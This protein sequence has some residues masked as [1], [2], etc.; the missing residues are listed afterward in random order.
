[1][2]IIYNQAK[3]VQKH[4][5]VQ[6][7]SHVFNTNPLKSA[8]K[9]IITSKEALAKIPQLT[10]EDVHSFTNDN[11]TADQIKK[12]LMANFFYYTQEI[13]VF[14]IT[15]IGKAKL[16]KASIKE[17]LETKNFKKPLEE[18]ENIV[19][20]DVHPDVG[21]IHL[22][23]KA[24]FPGHPMDQFMAPA[25]P[26]KFFPYYIPCMIEF[27]PPYYV[28]IRICKLA[29]RNGPRTHFN[30]ENQFLIDTEMSVSK[31]LTRIKNALTAKPINTTLDTTDLFQ[32]VVE[33][34]DKKEISAVL[35]KWDE[36]DKVHYTHRG[37]NNKTLHP[38]A[39]VQKVLKQEALGVGDGTWYFTDPSKTAASHIL[40]DLSAIRVFP[41]QGFIAYDSFR[42]ED[43]EG[44]VN[45]FIALAK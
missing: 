5:L 35:L 41:K 10:A 36:K 42:K 34:A 20:V 37:R 24:E 25:G 15:N 18:V 38:Y 31:L 4:D 19:S 1:M 27:L 44:N 16:T 11:L 33:T 9:E 23:Y 7:C 26:K 22:L 12:L 32:A 13:H 21:R 17:K 40:K 3:S 2:R 43:I 6:T 28:K 30:G 39:Y 29:I 8:L 14:H 45:A